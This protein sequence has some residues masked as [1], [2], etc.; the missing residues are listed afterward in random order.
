VAA[1]RLALLLSLLLSLAGC[2]TTIVPPREPDAPVLVYVVD[3]GR[4]SSLLFSQG[5]PN[6]MIEYTYGE[7]GWFAEN[8]TGCARSVPT[9]FWPTQGALGR[10]TLALKSDTVAVRARFSH[11]L[12]YPVLVARS[13]R[14]ALLRKLDA[15]FQAR[16]DTRLYQPAFETEFVYS[17]DRF[18]V[19]NNCN[20][21]T[22]TWLRDLGCKAKWGGVW[23]KFR[24][25]GE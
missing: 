25:A 22:R 18:Y 3:H 4:H 16:S 8:D 19:F 24:M 10:R 21:A 6:L 13:K 17:D 15:E 1:V 20:H 7:W 14:D 2:T 12:V 11:E 23:A 9:L 5:D